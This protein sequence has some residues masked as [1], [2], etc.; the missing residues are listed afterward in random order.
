MMFRPLICLGFLMVAG[1]GVAG[2]VSPYAGLEQRTIKALSEEQILDLRAGRGMGL[3]LAAELNGYPG[4]RHVLD[5]ADQLGLTDEQRR[6]VLELF[7]EMERGAIEIGQRIIQEEA[8]LDRLFAEARAAQRSV[9]LRTRT[10]ASL[11]G[12]LRAHHLGYHLAMHSLLTPEQVERYQEL[13]GYARASIPHPD[14]HG[15]GHS[16][17][18]GAR[19]NN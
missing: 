12:E 18:H 11:E 5:L 9:R 16:S 6:R 14:G 7:G 8:A 17:G 1:A 13:R 3:A 2:A 4:P 15:T 10:I 19:Q